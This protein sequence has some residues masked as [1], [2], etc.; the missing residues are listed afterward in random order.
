MTSLSNDCKNDQSSSSNNNSSD[1]DD[2]QLYIFCDLL[3][4]TKFI[5]STKTTK[6]TSVWGPSKRKEKKMNDQYY[7]LHTTPMTY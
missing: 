7:L 6:S 3:D 4:Q 5:K 1:S 2:G